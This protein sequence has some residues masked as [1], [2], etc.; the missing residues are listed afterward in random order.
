MK[1]RAL[2]TF[3]G[4][5][6][7]TAGLQ[8]AGFHVTGVDNRPQP[9]YPGECFRIA[10][11]L[12]YIEERGREFDFIWASPPCQAYTL[13]RHMGKRAGENAV[14]LIEPVRDLL[15]KIGV[16]YVIENVIGSPLRNAIVLCGS[17]FGLRVRRHRVFESNFV[18][19]RLPCSHQAERPVIAMGR[20][21]SVA[22]RSQKAADCGLW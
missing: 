22:P 1:P 8:R 15:E 21:P 17:S 10:D 16:P 3:C 12:K 7:V 9:R 4:A 2:D 20:W 6:G 5:G 18:L 14:E 11:A 13:M 19:F